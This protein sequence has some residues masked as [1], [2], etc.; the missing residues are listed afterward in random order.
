MNWTPEQ[1]EHLTKLWNE[2]HSTRVIAERLRCGLTRNA[3]IGKV[4]RLKLKPRL[5]AWY[6]NS[7]RGDRK[8]P[9]PRPPRKTNIHVE[10]VKRAPPR[11]RP[12]EFNPSPEDIAVGA[13]AALPG[14]N[15][16]TLVELQPARCKWP[17]GD[18]KPYLSCN[19][20]AVAGKP[21]CPTHLHRSRG[22]GTVGKRLAT[23]LTK[24]PST[25]GVLK[26]AGRYA[27]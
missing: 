26:F 16:V 9:P 21:Y 20:E 13:W 15:P 17:I 1:S 24:K 18:D 7:P 25:F 6:F 5:V 8:N 22:K 14:S 4:N 3:I 27:A 12:P 2:G 23:E 10:E 19:C 11:I